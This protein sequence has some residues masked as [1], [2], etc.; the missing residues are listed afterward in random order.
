MRTKLFWLAASIAGL[1]VAGCSLV[2]GG[3]NFQGGTG[4]DGGMG[5]DMG[6]P[7]N[8]TGVPVDGGPDTNPPIDANVTCHAP[9]DCPTGLYCDPSGAC[10]PGC[11]ENADCAPYQCADPTAHVCATSCAADDE[12]GGDSFCDSGACLPC[13]GDDDHF[14]TEQ[15]TAAQCARLTHLDGGDCN[16]GDGTVF[17]MARPDCA[18]P[19]SEAC[20][21]PITTSPMGVTIQEIGVSDERVLWATAGGLRVAN[22]HIGMLAGD[23]IPT[24][25][26]GAGG[27]FVGFIA[28]SGTPKLYAVPLTFDGT[29][30]P[31]ETL[32]SDFTV[33][34]AVIGRTYADT[35]DEY[36]T[37]AVVPP[38]GVASDAYIEIRPN[39][40]APA[41]PAFATTG[42]SGTVWSQSGSP[43]SVGL[44]DWVGHPGAVIALDSSSGMVP[45]TPPVLVNI[46][47]AIGHTSGPSNM[48]PGSWL[49]GAGGAVLWVASQMELG[50]WNGAEAGVSA[51][52]LDLSAY[53]T[54]SGPMPQVLSAE[55][56]GATGAAFFRD[57][58]GVAQE[59]HIAV[60]PVGSTA[61]PP[62]G[63]L[64]ILRWTQPRPQDSTGRTDAYINPSNVHMTELMVPG[65]LNPRAVGLAIAD[66]AN[67]LI[68]Y[69]EGNDVV[70]REVPLEWSMSLGAVED[71]PS[72]PFMHLGPLENLVGIAVDV[73][74]YVNDPRF[75][76]N[77]VGRMVVAA[78]VQMGG[79]SHELRSRAIEA[80]LI[81]TP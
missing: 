78:M 37:L 53:V 76:G 64:V 72:L 7:G 40:P 8:D 14:Y 10:M 5:N 20:P 52:T 15:A 28:T 58:F 50:F 77:A 56:R 22:G 51:P 32:F 30:P 46:D 16:D 6:T 44:V 24:L 67:V 47:P 9:T 79:S 73:A 4:T 42:L 26:S 49:A 36:A 39:R 3:S 31:A 19:Q 23:D 18:T 29:T 62:T 2:F 60:V 81:P 11:D 34:D 66:G 80:C 75:P 27:G 70:L 41:L 54:T 74:A 68:S 57:T 65:R 43:T 17:P 71:P 1:H 59:N 13:D 38:P 69:Q 12:C 33:A 21:L 63:R 45:G 25:P 48:M 61:T 55:Y 35:G